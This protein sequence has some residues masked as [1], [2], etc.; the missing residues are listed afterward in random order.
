M[1]KIA[2]ADIPSPTEITPSMYDITEGERDSTGT[3]HIDLIATKYKLQLKWGVLTKEEMSTLLN[4]MSSIN[5]SVT[6]DDPLSE[7]PK[8]INVYKGDR[9]MPVLTYVDGEPYYNGFAV[10]LIE[11]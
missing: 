1:I 3:M 4:L 2:G 5:F 7:S 9:S 6:F 11:L 10:N 8:T